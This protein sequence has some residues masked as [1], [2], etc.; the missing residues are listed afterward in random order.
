[1]H[2]CLLINM[3][4]KSPDSANGNLQSH[5]AQPLTS[6]R[7]PRPQIRPAACHSVL[8]QP[9]YRE[10]ALRQEASE[11]C[12]R[13]RSQAPSRCSLWL[14]GVTPPDQGSPSKL[15]PPRRRCLSS[16]LDSQQ[17]ASWQCSRHCHVSSIVGE[18]KG[19]LVNRAVVSS[20]GQVPCADD[21]RARFSLSLPGSSLFFFSRDRFLLGLHHLHFSSS[22]LNRRP[23]GRWRFLSPSL[24][25]LQAWRRLFFNRCRS[26]FNFDSPAS[27][28]STS[29]ELASVIVLF[30]YP[31]G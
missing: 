16:V 29:I 14:Y 30:Q 31:A 11:Q 25:G 17:W 21:S 18:M 4:S 24:L 10:P 15:L 19:I 6:S 9:H 2:P 5:P 3:T 7:N 27:S 26:L 1:M 28:S 22:S 13:S 12:L 8:A 20:N 23:S